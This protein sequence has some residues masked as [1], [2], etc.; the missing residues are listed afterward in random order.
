MKY[1]EIKDLD[2]LPGKRI[3]TND[4]FSFRCHSGL[5]CFNKCCRNLNL[6]LYPYDVLRLKNGL[7]I[8]SDEFLDNYIDIILRPSSF[9]SEVLLT[10]ADNDEKICP[11]LT[12]SGC[13]VYMDRPD[14]CRAFPIEQGMLYDNNGKKDKTINFFRPPEFCLGQYEEQVLTIK[15]WVRD[16]DAATHN[17]MTA[18]WAELRSMFQEN[19]WGSEG[20][21]GQKGKMAFMAS[22]NI[23]MFRDFV[24]NSSFLKR[25]KIKTD[26]KKKIKKDDVALMKL[27]FSWIK[28]YV[29]GI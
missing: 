7:G 18:L 24:F 14:A 11:F 19:P 28:L 27:G 1:V 16:Q 21:G 10:M 23:D 13:S 22:Y 3:L 17:K 8:T 12:E 2:K 4:N 9:F 25:Y 5:A 29:W 20:P 26:V 15:T 6:F